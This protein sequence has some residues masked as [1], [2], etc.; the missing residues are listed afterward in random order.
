MEK[1]AYLRDNWK[2]IRLKLWLVSGLRLVV[3]VMYWSAVITNMFLSV[4]RII[5]LDNLLSI[6]PQTIS[7][8]FCYYFTL[9]S[10]AVYLF[11]FYCIF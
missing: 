4:H 2:K 6:F 9:K 7:L 10:A 11:T 8:C 5:V 3:D 1:T